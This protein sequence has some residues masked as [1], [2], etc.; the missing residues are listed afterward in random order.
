MYVILIVL[1]INSKTYSKCLKISSELYY[2]GIINYH[3]FYTQIHLFSVT[4]RIINSAFILKDSSSS[5]G[6]NN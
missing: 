5:F 1:S 4:Y 3:H 6:Y 2:A